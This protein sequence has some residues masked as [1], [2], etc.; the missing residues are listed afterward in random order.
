MTIIDDKIAQI[1]FKTEKKTENGH[2]NNGLSSGIAKRYLTDLFEHPP[3]MNA[4]S[5]V[6]S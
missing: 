6:A 1:L 2:A 3:R 5:A 4:P